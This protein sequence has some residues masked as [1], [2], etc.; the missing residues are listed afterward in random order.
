MQ[1]L[2]G[3]P[4]ENYGSDAF[5]AFLHD[6][7]KATQFLDKE[8]YMRSLI[9]RTG[10]LREWLLFLEKYPLVLAPLT[11]KPSFKIDEDIHGGLRSRKLFS[12][13]EPSFS[14]NAL[15]LPSTAVPIALDNGAPHGVQIIGQRFREDTCLDAAETIEKKVG[16]LSQDLWNKV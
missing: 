9:K 10:I 1:Q 8:G 12:A 14:I 6:C 13:L 3:H 4:I 2:L 15:G 16:I 11:L 5:L 7:Y